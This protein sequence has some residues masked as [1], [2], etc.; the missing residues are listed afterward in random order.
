M[1]DLV[2]AGDANVTRASTSRGCSAT[3][4]NVKLSCNSLRSSKEC[5]RV[6]NKTRKLCEHGRQKHQCKE[7]GGSSICKHSKR[8]AVCTEC[9]GSSICQHGRQKHQCKECNGSSI[10]QHSKHRAVCKECEGSSICEHNKHRAVC[11]ECKGSSTCPHGRRRLRCNECEEQKTQGTSFA[12]TS[13]EDEG[14]QLLADAAAHAAPDSCG[15]A[16]FSTAKR[17]GEEELGKVIERVWE[18]ARKVAPHCI[19]RVFGHDKREQ[20][21]LSCEDSAVRVAT[22]QAKDRKPGDV[23]DVF[24]LHHKSKSR[25]T[26]WRRRHER[27]LRQACQDVRTLFERFHAQVSATVRSD[28]EEH[29]IVPEACTTP[30]ILP[31]HFVVS[32]T[33][34]HPAQLRRLYLLALLTVGVSFHSYTSSIVF[35]TADVRTGTRIN[36]L[37]PR[38]AISPA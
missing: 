9:K 34:T 5:G 32:V 29:Y 14:L 16:V 10:C 15:F 28:W 38:A 12:K 18:V 30:P 3:S 27:M 31:H 24:A 35:P 33:S 17:G 19:Q 22:M 13:H 4:T 36:H 6:S 37:P 21:I 26:K 11:K 8:K 1:C 7:C 25:S 20:V 2:H 23:L